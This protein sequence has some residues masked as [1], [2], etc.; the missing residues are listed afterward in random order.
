MTEES[1]AYTDAEANEF[2]TQQSHLGAEVL[3]RGKCFFKGTFQVFVAKY[4][5]PEPDGAWCGDRVARRIVIGFGRGYQDNVK[6]LKKAAEKFPPTAKLNL[7]GDDRSTWIGN[8]RAGWSVYCVPYAV[9][10]KRETI[11]VLNS[12]MGVDPSQQLS[13]VESS[14]CEVDLE[15]LRWM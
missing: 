5:V 13:S 2:P 12:V 15:S 9:F 1:H 6:Q 7:A 8:L 10:S 11:E 14:E 3:R 4:T